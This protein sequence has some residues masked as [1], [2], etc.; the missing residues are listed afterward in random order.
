MDLATALLVKPVPPRM[1]M[2]ERN[3]SL[4]HLS[5]RPD[6]SVP[7]GV[8]AV[9]LLVHLAPH[10]A[11]HALDRRRTTVLSVQL[12]R[13]SSMETVSAPMGTVFASVLI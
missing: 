7:P 3:V 4:Q 9:V 6:P 5:R 1:P 12:A 2:T 11:Q 10:R 13:T 8:S